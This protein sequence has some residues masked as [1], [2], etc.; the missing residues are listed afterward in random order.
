MQTSLSEMEVGPWG[1]AG[2]SILGKCHYRTREQSIGPKSVS[3]RYEMMLLLDE[4]P[5][6]RG[7]LTDKVGTIDT[8]ESN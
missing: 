7:I 4:C 1:I 5:V 6:G 8:E 3:S 2:F